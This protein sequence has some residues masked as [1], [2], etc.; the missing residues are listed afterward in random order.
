MEPKRLNKFISD[1]GF[2]S[3]READRLIEEERVTVNGK[4][5][6]AGTKV[7]AKDKVRIDDQLLTVREEKPV[8]LVFNKPSNMSAN[9]DPSVRDNVVRA[10]NYPASIQP[11][12]HLER[13]AEGVLFLCNDNDLVRRMTKSDNLFEKEYIVTVD[14]LISQDLINNLSTGGAAEAGEN[15]KKNFIAKEGPTRFRIVL[16]P[17]TNHNLKRMCET[18]GYKVVHLQRLRVQQITLAKLA[19]GHWRTLTEAEI[20]SL[21]QT[22][23]TRIAKSAEMGR[24][25]RNERYEEDRPARSRS[26][27]KPESGPRIGKSKPGGKSSTGNTLGKKNT[28]RPEA[29]GAKNTRSTGKGG[30]PRGGAAAPKDR[31]AAPRSS[32]PKN[33]GRTSA[34]GKGS[35]RRPR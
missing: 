16:P 17:N 26:Y 29:P 11:I 9:A 3:R 7:T 21:R 19:T 23:A 28:S 13:E 25:S 24:S 32:A 20:E 1:A 6:E 33:E 5:P 27:A 31:G 8:F 2:C 14:K 15:K 35:S 12:G 22:A 4:R 18:L 34:T 30:A 10:I